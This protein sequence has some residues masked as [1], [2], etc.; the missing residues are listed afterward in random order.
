VTLAEASIEEGRAENALD[1]LIEA[2]HAP[3]RTA[4]DAAE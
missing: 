2:S 4:L 3:A 1:A